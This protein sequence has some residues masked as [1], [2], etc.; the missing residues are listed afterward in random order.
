MAGSAWTLV[1]ARQDQPR[2]GDVQG[3]AKQR[4]EQEESGKAG[5]IEWAAEEHRHHEHEDGSG[6][7]QCEPEV[8]QHRWQGQD[9]DGEQGDHTQGKADVGSRQPWQGAGA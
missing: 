7:G 2:G 8:E 5:K 9:Q 3:Q 4:G 1:T 6:D